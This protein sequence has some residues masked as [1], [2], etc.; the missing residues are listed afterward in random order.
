[1]GRSRSCDHEIGGQSVGQE[2]LV[3][4]GAF[5]LKADIHVI[6]SIDPEK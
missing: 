3:M 4:Y 6:R 5:F 1:M 2:L